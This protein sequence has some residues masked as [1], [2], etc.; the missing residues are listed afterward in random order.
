MREN[1]AVFARRHPELCKVELRQ[2]ERRRRTNYSYLP[3]YQNYKYK[4]RQPEKQPPIV[5]I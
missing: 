4:S 2:I 5:L 3:I 1:I